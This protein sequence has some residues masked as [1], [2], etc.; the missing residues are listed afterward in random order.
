MGRLGTR[1]PAPG[2]RVPGHN[3]IYPRL[4]EDGYEDDDED[5]KEEEEE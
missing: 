3:D 2:G 4:H 1:D 5:E